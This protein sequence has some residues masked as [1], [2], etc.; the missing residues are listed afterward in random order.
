MVFHTNSPNLKHTQQQIPTAH[1]AQTM[2]LLS[3]N[4][5]ELTEKI[6]RELADNPAL[7]FIEGR[8]CPNCFR[9]L[10][11]GATCP[12]CSFSLKNGDDAPIIFV[13]PPD[14]RYLPRKNGGDDAPDLTLSA[15]TID[16]PT[17]VLRQI[18]PELPKQDQPIAVHIVSSLDDDGFLSIP[19]HEV[20]RYHHTTIEK[21]KKVARVIQK[22]DPIGVGS[23]NHQEALLVQLE[24]L[25]NDV[26]YPLM[27]R[28]VVE[29]GMG[30]LSKHQYTDMARMLGTTTSVA[31]EISSYISDNLNPFPARTHWGSAR[32]FTNQAPAVYYQPDVII[33]CHEGPHEPRLIVEIMWP[34]YGFIR[35]NPLYKQALKEA[36]EEKKQQWKSDFEKANLLVKCL[37]Q[38]NHTLVR[39]M[40]LLAIIQKNF[41]LHGDAQIL[42]ITRASLA[43]KLEVHESTISRAVSGKSV[44]LPSGKIIP[45]SRFFDRSLHIRTAM[46][47]IIEQESSPL[48][49]TKI[50]KILADQGYPIARRTVAKYRAMEG[51]LPAHMRRSLASLNL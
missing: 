17:F 36:P 49:D 9:R 27:T 51:I 44:Q 45:I 10:P 30:L 41:I 23:E 29:E 16:L 1:L 7:E 2:T 4:Y 32:H 5:L 35:V 37:S 20:A 46:K 42:P 8:H 28:K 47:T 12:K 34:L 38:R 21:V 24:V 14:N 33:K 13:S 6:E 39:L 40:Q 25:G 48:S 11:P 43:V 19:I 31:K 3:L 18:I 15:D 22:A 50:A 26:P